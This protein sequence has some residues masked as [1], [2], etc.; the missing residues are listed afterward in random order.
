[1]K[2]TTFILLGSALLA[3]LCGACALAQTG[4]GHAEP[5]N[6]GGLFTDVSKDHWAYA[7]LEYLA[8]RGIITG[9]P[10]GKFNGDQP[11]DRYTVAVYIARAMKYMQNNPEQVTMEDLDALKDLIFQISDDVAALQAKVQGGTS[12]APSTLETRMQRAEQDIAQLKTQI[13]PAAGGT[14]TNIAA[15][16]KRVQANFI[17]SL[18]ALLVAIIAVALATIGL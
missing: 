17:L 15:L 8:Q 12:T 3:V 7:D 4:N 5:V 14:T 18:T 13:Q 1:M 6:T 16:E 10:G 9:L 2:R 11:M